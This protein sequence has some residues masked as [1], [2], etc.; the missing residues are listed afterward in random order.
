MLFRRCRD[1]E[2]YSKVLALSWLHS[3]THHCLVE[4]S[5]LATICGHVCLVVL[6]PQSSSS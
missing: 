4:N 2:I 5:S 1:V 3:F 6:Q